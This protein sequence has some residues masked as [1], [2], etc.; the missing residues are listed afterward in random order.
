MSQS[1]FVSFSAMLKNRGQEKKVEVEP[2][3]VIDYQ[4][5]YQ[6]SENEKKSYEEKIQS[7][8]QELQ[9]S[10][11]KQLQQQEE[12]NQI[13]A[14]LEQT[15]LQ[16]KSELGSQL[17]LVWKSFLDKIF[18]DSRFQDVALI[19]ILEKGLLELVHQKKLIV[20][21]PTDKVELLRSRIADKPEWEVVARDDLE[22]G[23]RFKTEQ[24]EW[25]D[26]LKPVFEEFMALIFQISQEEE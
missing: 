23:V 18:Y 13:Q 21:V 8:E 7:L 6:Q 9:Q 12:F 14:L 19:E 3:V 26:R 15:V 4:A 1:N 22:V 20:E 5:L 11:Q 17:D 2:E 16:W 10:Q 24:I 25:E